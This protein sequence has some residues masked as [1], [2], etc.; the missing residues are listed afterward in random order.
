MADLTL[1]EIERLAVKHEAFGFGQVQPE[2]LTVHGF[3]PD[4]LKA[5]VAE[6]LDVSQSRRK[7][8]AADAVSHRPCPRCQGTMVGQEDH[9]NLSLMC[10]QC[11]HKESL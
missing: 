8:S 1:Q 3:E 2:G 7:L 5:F 6:L 4:G 9:G 11:K 10:V